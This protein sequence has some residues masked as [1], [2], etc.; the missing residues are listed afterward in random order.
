MEGSRKRK[1]EYDAGSSSNG[2][3]SSASYGSSSE[4]PT[5]NQLNG[6]P[7]SDKYHQLR[8]QRMKL[9]VF[10][11]LEQLHEYVNNNQIVIVE[12]ETGSGK[13]TQVRF[14]YIG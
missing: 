5:I 14:Q 6:R 7:Y 1:L 2:S 3:N 13:T 8:E 12:G 10:Q 9:P 4:V 11:F